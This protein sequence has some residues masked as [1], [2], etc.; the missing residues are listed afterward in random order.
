[1]TQPTAT[2]TP[3]DAF[4]IMSHIDRSFESKYALTGRIPTNLMV[5][6][7]FLFFVQSL[8]CYGV[9]VFTHYVCYE[10][11][12]RAPK[13]RRNLWE[14]TYFQEELLARLYRGSVGNGG[15]DEE[16]RRTLKK[17]IEI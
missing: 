4:R 17:T 6:F 9:T 15:G 11:S 16:R 10:L 7:L 5:G 14:I 2:V 8:L 13:G 1:M 12:R 3:H